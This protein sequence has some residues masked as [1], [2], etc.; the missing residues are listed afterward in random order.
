MNKFKI[1][2][3]IGVKEEWQTIHRIYALE[4]NGKCYVN[5]FI[6]D[7]RNKDKNEYKKIIKVIKLLTTEKRIK[8]PNHIK[9]CNNRK[10]K[11]IYEIRA[12]R[13]HSRISFFY[14]YTENENEDLI[15]VLTFWKSEKSDIVKQNDF[16]EKTFKIMQEYKSSL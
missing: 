6:L 7:V 11:D 12:H 9:S 14:E 16:F 13:G 1:V 10:Y 3:V 2:P 5:D 15:C 4:I 8:N